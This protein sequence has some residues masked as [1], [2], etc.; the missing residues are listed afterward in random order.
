MELVL[1]KRIAVTISKTERWWPGKV[2]REILN[3]VSILSA[4]ETTNEWISILRNLVNTP[5]SSTKSP[6]CYRE[7]FQQ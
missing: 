2:F 7:Q 5:V 1:R 4:I 3:D 6:R